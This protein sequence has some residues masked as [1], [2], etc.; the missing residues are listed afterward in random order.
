[1]A[2]DPAAFDAFFKA[3]V[4]RWTEVARRAGISAQ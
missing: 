4:A 2:T 3:E 1:M